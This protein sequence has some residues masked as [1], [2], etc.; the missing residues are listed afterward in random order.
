ML[1]QVVCETNKS[2]YVSRST[3]QALQTLYNNNALT[4]CKTIRLK[5]FHDMQMLLILCGLWN[6]EFME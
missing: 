4:A 6:I 3:I 2:C 1:F 5:N